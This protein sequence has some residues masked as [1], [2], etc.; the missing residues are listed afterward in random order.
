MYLKS[1]VYFIVITHSVWTKHISNLDSRMELRAIV[2][3]ST[4]QKRFSAQTDIL[5]KLK[6]A[7]KST[8]KHTHT[9]IH[10]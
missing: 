10:L 5:F 9:Y 4:D 1:A 8:H 6:P 7:Q 2:L 3:D